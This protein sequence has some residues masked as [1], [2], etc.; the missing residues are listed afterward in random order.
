MDITNPQ[1]GP[2]VGLPIGIGGFQLMLLAQTKSSQA[3]AA[4]MIVAY[5]SASGLPPGLWP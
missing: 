1:D 5:T 2:T 4:E 3:V